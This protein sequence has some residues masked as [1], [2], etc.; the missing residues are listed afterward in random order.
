M[1]GA[2]AQ[3]ERSLIGERVRRVS[4]MQEAKVSLWPTSIASCERRQTE[5]LRRIAPPGWHSLPGIGGTIWRIGLDHSRIVPKIKKRWNPGPLGSEPLPQS[6]FNV[7]HGG[8]RIGQPKGRCPTSQPCRSYA[9]A[10]T[11]IGSLPCGVCAIV[12]R[13]HGRPLGPPR[14][15]QGISSRT[16]RHSG[17]DRGTTLMLGFD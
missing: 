14:C 16:E 7:S 5:A 6:A 10:L 17:V 3:F 11:S 15:R 2:V 13:I 9:H 4:T 1:I 8:S 12:H